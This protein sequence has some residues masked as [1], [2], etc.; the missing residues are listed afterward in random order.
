MLRKV[1]LAIA[2]VAGLLLVPQQAASAEE[3]ASA[4]E[5]VTVV[6]DFGEAGVEVGCAP[7]SP[8]T[9]FA[10]LEAA[11]FTV[12]E[13]QGLPGFLCTIDGAPAAETC[14]ATPPADAYWSY[15]QAEPGG[16]WEYSIVGA[17]SASPAT[18]EGW[19]FGAADAPRLA[20]PSVRL[21]D[22]RAAEIALP[23]TPSGSG[24][25]PIALAALAV[26]IGGGLFMAYRHREKLG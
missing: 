18:I 13:V 7:G 8:D 16:D 2:V 12:R 22:S 17:A 3:C 21:G 19:A 25:G 9:G 24:G 23:P 5:G 6:V 1:L 11:G 10:A 4:D 14:T 20:P 15:W 26:L